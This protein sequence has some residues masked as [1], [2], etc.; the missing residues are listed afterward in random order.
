MYELKFDPDLCMAC[1]TQDCLVKCQHMDIDQEA[2]RTEI[3]KLA[4]GEDSFV[5]RDCVTC[6][7]CEEYCPNGNHP[8]YLIV[9]MQEELGM[10]PLPDPLVKSGVQ[11][12]IPFRGEPVIDEM[13]GTALN[14][15]VFSPLLGRVAGSKLFE[16][17][18]II[19]HDSRK[20]FHYFCQLMYLH[21]GK[22]SV[23]NE[24]LDGI[25][26][27]L[28]AHGAK[29]IVHFHDECYGTYTSYAPAFGIEVPFK[30]IHLFEFLYNRLLELK[31]EIRPLGYKVVYQRPCSSRLSSD[32][33]PFVAKIFDLI[34][35]EYMDREYKDENAMCCGA[36]ILG[37]KKEGS[38]VYCAEIQKKNIDDMK[39]AGG[40]ICVFNCP[41][42]MQTL[43]MPVSKAG[44]MPLFMSDLCRLAIGE[45]VG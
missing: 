42:C 45:K 2:A 6:Y 35:V 41:A 44:I 24:R 17:L 31:D 19:S 37:Q 33:H 25:I 28:A 40:Q 11:V 26:Q 36:T 13:E 8:F 39:K 30:S 22:T 10:F 16:G 7:A 43:G 38:R 21:Y 9:K 1:D 5:L 18:P 29:E 34:S 3:L 32:K 15:G 14:M 12:G 27:T 20:M 23:I 4:G